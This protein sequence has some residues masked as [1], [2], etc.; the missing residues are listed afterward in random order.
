MDIATKT[1]GRLSTVLVEEGD[2]VRAGQVLA[3]M[4]TREADA[5][6]RQAEA[7]MRQA[8]RALDARRSAAVQQQT[9]LQLT[10]AEFERTRS[11]L[12]SGFAT[13]QAMDQRTSARDGA[14]AALNTAM[15]QI[16]E[17]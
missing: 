15:A 1:A 7:Q 11:L 5:A 13:R 12:Q 9:Q 2:M 6:R 3:R 17:A 4:D 8:Q 10:Q 16:G 14:A